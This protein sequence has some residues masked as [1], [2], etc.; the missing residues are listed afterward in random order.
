M[1]NFDCVEMKHKA[2]QIIHQR[3]EGMSADEK[4]KYWQEREEDLRKRIE[5]AK[6]KKSEE[7]IISR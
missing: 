6:A 4:M 7:I 1:K 5:L 3:L 2:Q